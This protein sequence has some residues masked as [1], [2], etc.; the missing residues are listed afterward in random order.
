MKTC[1]NNIRF[2]FILAALLPVISI[3][4]AAIGA[5]RVVL[6]EYYTGIW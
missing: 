5:E 6:G 1:R 2:G 4:T 3:S